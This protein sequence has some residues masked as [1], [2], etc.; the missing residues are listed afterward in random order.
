M[1][2][3]PAEDSRVKVFISYAHSSEAHKQ[4]V[5]DLAAT[6]RGEGLVV[7]LDADVTTPQGPEEGWPKWMKRQIKSADWVLIFFDDVYR[8]RFDGEEE[9]DKG[10]GATWE[11]A[12]ITHLLY[13]QSMR[14]TSFIPLLADGAG[15]YVIPD[16]FFGANYYRIPKQSKELATALAQ[17]AGMEPENHPAEL[18]RPG[19]AGRPPFDRLP[20]AQAGTLFGRDAQLDDLSERLRWGEDV[21]VWGPAGFG[22]TALAA[23]A[24]LRVV[25]GDETGLPD[26]AFPD[27][28]VLV[29]LYRLKADA[30]RVWHELADRFA[31]ALP[32]EL[33]AQERATRACARR[34][35]LV[36]IEGAEEA[37]DG[38]TLQKLLSV[39]DGTATRLVLTRNKA[40]VFCARPIQLDEELARDDALS[41][42]TR[43]TEGRV[44]EDVLA[45]VVERFGGHPLPLTWAGCQLALGEER[46]ER[47]L[48]EM[49]DS[50]L[51]RLHEPG[52]EDHSV[53][54]LY[55]RSVCRVGADAEAVLRV[56]GL[57]ATAAFPVGGAMAALTREDDDLGDLEARAREARARE[58]LCQWASDAVRDALRP[59]PTADTAERIPYALRHATALLAAD[60]SGE[61]AGTL[62]NWLLYKAQDR[63]FALGRLSWAREALEAVE[64]WMGGAP[65]A[66]RAKQDWQ[67]EFSVLC[68]QKGDVQLAQDDLSGAQAGD[69]AAARREYEAGLAIAQKLCELDATNATWQSDLAWFRRQLDGL[70][71]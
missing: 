4:T 68:S 58:A 1:T 50:N 59:G 55:D 45:G 17:T 30:D 37:G 70:D 11:G 64:A 25:G 65:A 5:Q 28:V 24:V 8:R 47:F 51:P 44:G 2:D 16:E 6:L 35:A 40:Q 61:S 29:D 13:R 23:E 14:N 42:L 26:S 52:Y 34:R 36:V 60:R 10:L 57:L 41:L 69:S 22:K 63:F 20:R 46:P 9:P 21:C 7:S 54:W 62:P 15:L 19:G 32:P 53:K 49:R 38:Q 56:A 18:G 48:T 31:P 27:G 66:R 3:T 39:L 33:P 67:R 43:L 12:I 71:G